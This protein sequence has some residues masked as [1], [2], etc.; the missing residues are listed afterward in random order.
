MGPPG[1]GRNA[2]RAGAVRLPRPGVASARA[3]AT[4]CGAPTSRPRP[5][6][7][8][9]AWGSASSSTS[10]AG[11]VGADAL[12]RVARE[13]VTRRLSYLAIDDPRSR[14][15]GFASP[16]TRRAGGRAGHLRADTATPCDV[17]R[18][19][20][21]APRRGGAG[22][23]RHRRPVRGAGG[24]ERRHAPPGS[25]HGASRRPRPGRRSPGSSR[26]PARRTRWTPS[27]TLR[28]RRGWHRCAPRRPTR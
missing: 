4:G 18:L 9:R 11:F 2:V 19:R 21:P 24:R 27:T 25:G 10:P 8:R 3:A 5:I 22:R 26:C 20:V 14:R 28:R 7:T 12:R 1:R 23:P 13:G 15:P 17:D 6:P 16:S